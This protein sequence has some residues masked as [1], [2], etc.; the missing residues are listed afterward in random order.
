MRRDD[1]QATITSLGEELD[2]IRA[3]VMTQECVDCRDAVLGLT[4][5]V[6]QLIALLAIIGEN[7][8][9]E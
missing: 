2:D 9:A 3:K 4:E 7:G 8:I 1:L 6:S 5:I